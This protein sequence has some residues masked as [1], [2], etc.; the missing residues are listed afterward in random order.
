M[1]WVLLPGM[2][3]TGDLVAPFVAQAPPMDTCVVV[4]YPKSKKLNRSELLRSIR[5]YLPAFE[6]YVII[7]E[8][9]SGQFGIEIATGKPARLR[10]LVLVNSFAK[11]PLGP[12]GK[13]IGL[14]L[15]EFFLR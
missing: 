15:G 2:D 4:R 13:L 12:I 8:S 6:D 11:C 1:N 14:I 3:G 10:A 5:E 7:A 9:F